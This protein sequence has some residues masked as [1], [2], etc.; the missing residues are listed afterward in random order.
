MLVTLDSQAVP[1]RFARRKP[2]A[3]AY[4][5]C[6]RECIGDAHTRT[7]KICDLLPAFEGLAV[8]IAHFAAGASD[9]G[10]AAEISRVAAPDQPQVEQQDIAAVDRLRCPVGRHVP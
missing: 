10:I 2:D 6:G 3:L 7:Q 4:L 1:E 5:A 8:D 9:D